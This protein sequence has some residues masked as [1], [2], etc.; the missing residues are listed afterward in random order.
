MLK[1]NTFPA[2]ARPPGEKCGIVTFLTG[3]G[4]HSTALF[5]PLFFQGVLG[6][7]ATGSGGLLTP[8]ML[9][10]VLGAIVSGRRLSRTGGQYRRQALISTGAM[11]VGIYLISTMN[12]NTSFAQSVAYI[13]LMGLGMGGTMSTVALA[14]QNS[15]PFRLVGSATSALQ[16]YRLFSGTLGL[17]VLGVVLTASFSSR[18]EETVSDSVR[19]ALPQGQFETIKQNPRALVDP[20]AIDTLRA[21]FAERGLD[22]FQM[23]DT[24][25]AALS[26]ALVGALGDAFTM[27]AV[28]VALSVGAALFL[29]VE[30]R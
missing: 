14:V 2:D 13:S 10:M 24:F 4:L 15:V 18:L 21:G 6:S 30:N 7:T 19:T 28:V 17:A 5:T 20:K 23:A 25:L 29:R 3:F 12:E 27:S 9:A 11:A 22:G 1:A 8:M 16:F 26:S